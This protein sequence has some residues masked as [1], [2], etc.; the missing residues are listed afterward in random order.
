MFSLKKYTNRETHKSKD[1]HLMKMSGLKKY[2]I[3]GITVFSIKN[4][5]SYD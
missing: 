4:Y 2:K 5:R 3:L 1:S